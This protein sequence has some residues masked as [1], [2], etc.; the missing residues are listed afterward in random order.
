V[1][2]LDVLEITEVAFKYI[3]QQKVQLCQRGRLVASTRCYLSCSSF[4]GVK[5]QV[6]DKNGN[7]I[8]NAIVEAKGRPHICPYRTNEHGE[9]FLLLLPGKYVIN[10]SVL[11]P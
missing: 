1:T 4:I 6:T 5:G 7:P 10:V 9:Y 8:P 3:Q 2:L 11:P